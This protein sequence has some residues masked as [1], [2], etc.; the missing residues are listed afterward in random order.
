MAED[1]RVTRTKRRL[2]QALLDLIDEVGYD[3][4]TIKQLTDRADVARSTFYSHYGDKEDLL[5]AGFDRWLL[6]FCELADPHPDAVPHF[7][8]A[9]PLLRHANSQKRFFE[10]T[11]VR[12]PSHRVRRRLREILAT[13]AER[14]LVAGDLMEGGDATA[15]A[16]G[17]AIAGAFLGLIEWWFDQGARFTAEEVDRIFQETV[18]TG[19]AR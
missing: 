3:S 6:S 10:S 1:R 14:E 17:R 19:P 16:R 12:G 9:L 2:K 18:V 11:I 15:T 4:I 13:V 8:F 5:F 7:H